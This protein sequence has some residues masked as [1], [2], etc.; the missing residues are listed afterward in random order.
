MSD[1]GEITSPPAAVAPAPQASSSGGRHSLDRPL[2]VGGLVLSVAAFVLIA[3]GLLAFSSASSARD[4]AAR[5]GKERRAAE[6]R[7][8]AAEGDI[9]TVVDEGNKVVDQIDKETDAANQVT[10][11]DDELE[12]L[13]ENA[14]DQFN[15]GYESSANAT[16]DNQGRP[17]LGEEQGLRVQENQALMAARDAQNKLRQ[18]LAG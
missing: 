13:L 16:V 5:L 10:E 14:T 4:D 7:E 3:L 9:S 12:T 6:A 15:A 17:V 1:S 18:A 8:I 2:L 11:K